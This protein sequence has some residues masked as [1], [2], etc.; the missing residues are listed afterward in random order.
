MIELKWINRN[1]WIE[2][3]ESIEWNGSYSNDWIEM[4]EMIELKW[5]NWYGSY[6]ND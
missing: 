6:S 5:L 1:G 3:D 4:D 2:M